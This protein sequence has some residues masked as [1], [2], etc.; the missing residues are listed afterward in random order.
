MGPG[1]GGRPILGTIV[2][3]GGQPLLSWV[4]K[5]GGRESSEGV[6]RGLC[7]RGLRLGIGQRGRK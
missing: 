1:E 3:E 6:L 7:L 2:L 4:S 5:L